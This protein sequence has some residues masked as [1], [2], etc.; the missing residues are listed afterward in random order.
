LDALKDASYGV[1]LEGASRFNTVFWT[2]RVELI[3]SFLVF[4]YAL[5]SGRRRETVVVALTFL[6]IVVVGRVPGWPHFLAFLLGAFFAQSGLRAVAWAG[7]PFIIAGLYLGGYSSNSLYSPIEKLGVQGDV[8]K[9]ICSTLGAALIFLAV[10]GDT[11]RSFLE[12]RISQFLGKISYSLYLVHA[13]IIIGVGCP[14]FWW[15]VSEAGVDRSAA[16]GMAL[17]VSLPISV[18]V[19]VVFERFIDRKAILWGKRL[20]HDALTIDEPRE[21]VSPRG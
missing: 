20:T 19:A 10:R 6:L 11:G 1:L 12:S 9:W 4:G 16:V 3:G 8:M 15:A 5:L 7:W 21:S 2:M 18:L 14:I 17:V 13:P